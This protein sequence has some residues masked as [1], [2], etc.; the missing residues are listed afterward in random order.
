MH[1]ACGKLQTNA[2]SKVVANQ[3]G[4]NKVNGVY[5]HGNAVYYNPKAPYSM[6][7]ISAD[8]DMHSGGIWKAASSISD[9]LNKATRT[10]TFN[11]D[12]SIRIGD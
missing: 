9:L 7:Y 11:W 1:N 3:L 12:L 4:Y 2:Q 8:I 6:Q 5:S 10:V